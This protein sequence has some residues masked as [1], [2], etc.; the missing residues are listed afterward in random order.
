MKRQPLLLMRPLP[1][2]EAFERPL[3]GM[4][5]LEARLA[6]QEA[7]IEVLA[8]LLLAACAAGWWIL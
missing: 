2:V 5:L 1:P 6:K 8:V 4:P 7:V 3:A